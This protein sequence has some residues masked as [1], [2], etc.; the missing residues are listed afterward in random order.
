MNPSIPLLS[1]I[2]IKSVMNT[3]N[4]YLLLISVYA[5]I[6]KKQYTKCVIIR[7]AKF[8]YGAIHYNASDSSNK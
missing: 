7:K 5:I 4:K 8:K 6:L 3:S 1:Y 2:T